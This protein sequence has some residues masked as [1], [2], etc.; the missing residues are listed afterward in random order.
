MEGVM[1]YHV[2]TFEAADGAGRAYT[3]LAYAGQANFQG[4]TAPEALT[5]KTLDGKGVERLRQ[6]RYKVK[7]AG[8]VLT[9]DSPNAP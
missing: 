2:C 5:L 4:V 3:V 7:G 9:S 8:V 6:G 1:L